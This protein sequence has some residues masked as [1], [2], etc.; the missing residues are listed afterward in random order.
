M[1]ALVAIL[2]K[3]HDTPISKSK[4]LGFKIQIQAREFWGDTWPQN[5]PSAKA[6]A[7]GPTWR[8][9]PRGQPP[10]LIPKPVGRGFSV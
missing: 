6:T 3:S 10:P 1:K 7:R 5:R 9:A 8:L 4:S 2:L